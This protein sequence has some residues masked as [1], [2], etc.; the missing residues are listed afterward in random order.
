MKMVYGIIALLMFSSSAQAADNYFVKAKI[1]DGEKL[2]GAPAMQVE[3][4][5]ETSVIESGLYELTFTVKPV[6]EH[7]AGISTNLIVG[8]KT[9]NPSVVVEF[10]AEGKVT[11]DGNSFSIVV[12]RVGS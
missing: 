7:A 1:Y 3:S 5:V 6:G 4:N 11:V 2:V 9:L 10:G 12:N 8:G